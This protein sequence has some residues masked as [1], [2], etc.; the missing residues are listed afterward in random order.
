[1]KLLRFAPKRAFFIAGLEAGFFYFMRDKNILTA[2]RLLQEG[3][4]YSAVTRATGITYK[5]LR[6][7]ESILHWHGIEAVLN[8]KNRYYQT[9]EKARAAIDVLNGREISAVA[10]ELGATEHSVRQWRDLYAEG[11]IEALKDKRRRKRA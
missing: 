11:G 9:A 1:M 6:R 8:R 10:A 7:I 4:P 2:I 5:T 3:K